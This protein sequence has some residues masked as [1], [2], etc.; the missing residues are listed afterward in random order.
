MLKRIKN[1]YYVDF[2]DIDGTRRTRALG[3]TDRELA[4][5]LHAEYMK[6]VETQ[7][8]MAKI[9][10]DFPDLVTA[11]PPKT[12][13]PETKRGALKLS[14][15]LEL[16]AKRRNLSQSHRLIWNKFC[17]RT[18]LIYAADVTPK[19]AL[20][21]LESNYS[22]GNGKTYNNIKS[23][24][25]TIFRCCLVDANLTES[26][27]ESIMNKR[28]TDIESHRNL[29]LSEIDQILA[30]GSELVKTMTMLS[31]WT[32]QRLKDCAS[33]TP[34]M[35]DWE[36]KVIILQPGKTKRFKKWVCAPLFPELENYLREISCP[37]E[38]SYALNF[39]YRGNNHFCREIHKLFSRLHICDTSEG[40][41]SFHSIRGTAITWFKENGIHG[42]TLR[43]ITGHTTKE[44]EDIY[45]RDIATISKIATG[46]KRA[47]TE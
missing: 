30:N 44:V 26:P 33:I 34:S 2:Y 45:A 47:K 1:R 27:F 29:T 28:I 5:K 19:Y 46:H 38:T 24:L 12:A 16:A 23:A 36:R 8:C 7:K 37:A 31:R 40:K 4:V 6:Y 10:R 3:T 11:P 14:E 17:E 39:G 22:N 42:E 18:K 35:I 21:Y 32:G 25:N 20:S 43:S 9:A 41:A 15:M 13:A